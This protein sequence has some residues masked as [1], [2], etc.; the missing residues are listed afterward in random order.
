MGNKGIS[1]T[2]LKSMFWL[3][4]RLKLRTL[5]I[6]IELSPTRLDYIKC[7][8][9]IYTFQRLNMELDL[10]S[11]FGHHV[12]SCTHWLRPRPPPPPP[13]FGLIY[14]A[15][16]VSQDIRHLFVAPWHLWMWVRLSI[17][18]SIPRIRLENQPVFLF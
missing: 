11:L 7:L 10:L 14:R 4:N 17:H 12:Y 13:P 8:R 3:K 9:N 15:L 5:E 18:C 6:L 1:S 16:L 2:L